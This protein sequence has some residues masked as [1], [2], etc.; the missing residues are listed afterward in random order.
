[1]KALKNTEFHHKNLNFHPG[2]IRLICYFNLQ[3]SGN[4]PK[5]DN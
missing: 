1:M 4:S 2:N 3:G 5:A